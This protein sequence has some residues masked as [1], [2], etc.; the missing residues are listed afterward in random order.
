MNLKLIGMLAAFAAVG[1]VACTSETDSGDDTDTGTSTVVDTDTDTDVTATDTD[2]TD[3]D[4]DVAD[5]DTGTGPGITGVCA[6]NFCQIE[7]AT[8]DCAGC[9][10]GMMHDCQTEYSACVGDSECLM[11][12]M[13]QG[14][15]A[16]NENV[17]ALG[18]CICSPET[19]ECVM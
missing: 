2:V 13:G 3:T 5:T 9:I 1:V 7:P 6:D 10:I 12:F 8:E 4:T 15:S 11:F 14:G 17:Q 16:E 18:D 19:S